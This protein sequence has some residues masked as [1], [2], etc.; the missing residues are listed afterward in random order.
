M[1]ESQTVLTQVRAQRSRKG[2]AFGV[3]GNAG[4][5]NSTQLHLEMTEPQLRGCLHQ[6]VCRQVCGDIFLI[7]D[8]S[9]RAQVPGAVSSLWRWPWVL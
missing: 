2:Q 5:V 1:N 7:N 9:G 4:F 3:M 6:I 8:W